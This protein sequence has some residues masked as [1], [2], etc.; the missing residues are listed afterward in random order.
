MKFRTEI[1]LKK[2]HYRQIDY[3]S[4]LVLLGSCFTEN[5]GNKFNYFKFQ[6]TINPFGILFHPKAIENLLLN[7]I[8]EKE[9]SE[10]DI[11][12][13]NE[14]WHCFE[15]HS[16]ASNLSKEVLLNYLNNAIKL[17]Y[18]KINESTHIII[19]L[20]TAWVYRFIETDNIVANCH[21]VPQKKFLK[22][23]LS[24]D[25]ITESLEA[26][27][28]LIKL[29]NNKATVL[30]TISPV[31]HLK[32]GFIENQQSKAHLITAIQN[33]INENDVFY[34]P[35][36]EIMIDELRDY[37]FYKDD[38]VHPNE[39]A[40]NYIWEKF[41]LVWIS[42]DAQQTMQK[43]ETIQ[44]GLLHRPFNST[45]KQHQEFLK[46]ITTKINELQSLFPEISF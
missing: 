24:I 44:K 42:K 38:M 28:T 4:K 13:Y 16:K 22:E 17:T 12:F 34:F 5:I 36:Y 32:N 11:F 3:Y 1:P 2:Q 25:K 14:Q 7:A 29:I 40:I 15:A 6:N 45:S 8:N 9:Y 10:N 19:T 23:L 30:F 27:T 46:N 43:I 31:R 18:Q 21:K 37:R 20:G 41:N 39:T 35:S 26:I 33:V